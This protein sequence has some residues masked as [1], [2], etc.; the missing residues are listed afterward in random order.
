M[1]GHRQLPRQRVPAG[2]ACRPLRRGSLAGRRVGPA[3]TRLSGISRLDRDADRGR[4]DP[5]WGGGDSRPC[6]SGPRVRRSCCMAIPWGPRWRSRW[7]GASRRS[8]SIS[9]RRSTRS[10]MPCG[11][12]SAGPV[13]APAR[14]LPLGPA[15]P[16]R[17]EPS[18]DRPGHRRPGGAGQARA[19]FGRGRGAAGAVR[20]GPGR[21]RL[22]LRRAGS[23]GRGGVSR[24]RRGRPVVLRTAPCRDRVERGIAWSD[25]APGAGTPTIRRCPAPFPGR[26]RSV[27]SAADRSRRAPAPACITSRRS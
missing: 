16:R 20:A 25:A 2:A 26:T 6:G 11:C 13:L 24:S 15:H 8:G 23:R 7:P 19:G 27:R 18:P 5:R 17:G 3:G 14:H 22:D 10:P 4:A 12:M 9:R 21:S 1:R